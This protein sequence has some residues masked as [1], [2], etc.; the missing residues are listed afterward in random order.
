MGGN[1]PITNMEYCQMAN[2]KNSGFSF[3]CACLWLLFMDRTA[4]GGI[5][6]RFNFLRG[7]VEK[8]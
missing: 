2:G 1:E 8:V 4:T 5:D 6:P 7:G 3:H